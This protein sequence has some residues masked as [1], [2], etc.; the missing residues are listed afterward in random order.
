M[1]PIILIHGGAGPDSDFI[2]ANVEAY[3]T[4]LRAALNKGYE[5]LETNGSALDAVEAAVRE[6]EDNPLFNC[7][8][9]SALTE[10]GNTEMCASIMDGRTKANGAVAIVTGVRHPVSLAKAAAPNMIIAPTMVSVRQR[11]A[12]NVTTRLFE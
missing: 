1:K 12:H 6:M 10:S 2:K 8:R 5:I 4:G 7:G 11:T 3:E 9:G